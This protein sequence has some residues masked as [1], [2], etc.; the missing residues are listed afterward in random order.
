MPI[1]ISS[2]NSGVS[3]HIY[4]GIL[5]LGREFEGPWRAAIIPDQG[6]LPWVLKL[7]SVR[8]PAVLQ[9]F[10]PSGDPET[11]LV[12]VLTEFVRMRDLAW[13]S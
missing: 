7:E 6:L 3:A 2:R 8:G 5:Q 12:G 13:V 1:A 9:S 11:D 4:E 10:E